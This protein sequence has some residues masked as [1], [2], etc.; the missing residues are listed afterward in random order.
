MSGDQEYVK[1][2]ERLIRRVVIHIGRLY[3]APNWL[4][5]KMRRQHGGLRGVNNLVLAVGRDGG[6]RCSRRPNQKGESWMIH[7]PYAEDARRRQGEE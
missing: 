1:R 2:C 3:P 6:Q 5:K 4:W 7:R